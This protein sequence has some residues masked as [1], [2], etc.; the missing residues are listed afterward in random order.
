MIVAKHLALTLR[1][2]TAVYLAAWVIAAFIAYALCG[3]WHPAPRIARLTMAVMVAYVAAF[4]HGLAVA[5][6]LWDPQRD[7]GTLFFPWPAS[8]VFAVNASLIAWVLLPLAAGV[9]MSL[10]RRYL[11]VGP[12]ITF[13]V[14]VGLL[15]LTAPLAADV[16]LD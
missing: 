15:W 12:R 4:L 14:A 16:V 3:R 1:D 11:T 9:G 13:L 7:T 8:L 10:A 6:W 2:V 5:T